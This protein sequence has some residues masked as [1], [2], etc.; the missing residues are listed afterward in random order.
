[1]VQSQSA[2]SLKKS[3]KLSK[4]LHFCS[5]CQLTDK[6]AFQAFFPQKRFFHT[7]KFFRVFNSINR[8]IHRNTCEI[9]L[10]DSIRRFLASFFHRTKRFLEEFSTAC[11]KLLW[12]TQNAK[13]RGLKSKVR[14]FC[15]I[16]LF[17]Q[18]PIDNRSRQIPSSDAEALSEVPARFPTR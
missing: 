2:F 3:S 10:F 16:L 12:K 11:G 6:T 14:L 1:M 15:R 8:L 18:S 4:K 5:F 9:A 17:L 7:Q 13:N